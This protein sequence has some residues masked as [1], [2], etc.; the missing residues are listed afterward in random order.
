MVLLYKE[1]FLFTGDHIF[2]DQE[3]NELRASRGVCWYSWTEQIK[4][5]EKL[6]SEKFEWVLPGHG[7]WAF[8]GVEEAHNK[9]KTLIASMKGRQ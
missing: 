2:V 5:T 4:S 8:F 6:E 1:K 9:L 3:I 7:G